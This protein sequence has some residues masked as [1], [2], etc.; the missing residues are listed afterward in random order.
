MPDKKNSTTKKS[1]HQQI[2]EIV[3]QV[4]SISEKL[5]IAHQTI[6]DGYLDGRIIHIDGQRLTNFGS[7]SYMG[8][9]LDPRL[10]AG[11]IDAVNRYGSQFA[12]SRAYLSVTLY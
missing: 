11:A 4:S 6:E 9:E 3:D 12:S 10:K 2:I 1:K 8:L 7:C 5:G